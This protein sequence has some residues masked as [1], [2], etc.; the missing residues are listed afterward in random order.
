M[1]NDNLKPL[2]Q[3]IG[4]IKCKYSRKLMYFVVKG[5]NNINKYDLFIIYIL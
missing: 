1:T 2:E 4:A 5:Q 3:S